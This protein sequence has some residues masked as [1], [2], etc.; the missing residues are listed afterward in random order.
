MG[1]A[2]AVALTT[3]QESVITVLA[4]FGLLALW[5]RRARFRNASAAWIRRYV[6]LGALWFLPAACVYAAVGWWAGFG[7][8]LLG[9][10]VNGLVALAC[11][12]W[13][14]GYGLLA[15]AAALGLVALLAG[16]CTLG[17]APR[18]KNYLGARR[19]ALLLAA[20]LVGGGI[21]SAF[22]ITTYPGV[23]GRTP[24]WEKLWAVAPELLS[25]SSVFRPVLWAM[26]FYWAYLLVRV[27]RAPS[28]VT[29]ESFLLLLALTIP[30]SLGLRSL[31]GSYLSPYPEVPAICYPFVVVLAPYL[32][33]RW[34]RLPYG[35][36][37]ELRI[38]VP[39][40]PAVVT[41]GLAL[42]YIAV[43]LIGGYPTVLSNR[44]FAPLETPAGMVHVRQAA[45]N[46]EILDY[47]LAHTGPSDPIL[48][49]PYG[50]GMGFATGRPSY[51]FT[52]LWRQTVVPE[53]LQMLDLQKVREHPP[54]IVIAADKENFG[55]YYGLMGTNACLFPS[56]GW[57]PNRLSW[58]PGFVFPA[59]RW[60]QENYHVD[61]RVGDWLLL[62][63]GQGPAA[64]ATSTQ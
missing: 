40:R 7:N 19:Y 6:F 35:Y 25:T 26:I 37:D 57:L 32:V 41:A 63:P 23:L 22:V 49:L 39:A 56:F 50:G 10:Q 15:A 61:R 42:A 1:I 16:A 45:A 54:K 59:I 2:A 17:D 30:V 55:S 13:P 31:F 52:T 14:T 29:R 43:R 48:E 8:M 18:W 21:Y 20:S 46:R 28:G 5:E 60:I 44:E 38:R 12:W 58:R 3:K 34:L 36:P 4:V 62:L 47:V 9:I 64:N 53:R 24:L 27:F 11:P 33:L 51:S